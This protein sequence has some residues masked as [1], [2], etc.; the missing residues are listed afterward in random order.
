MAWRQQMNGETTGR[1][2][3]GTS[4]A[5]LGENVK[6]LRLLHQV[7]MVVSAAVLAF[8]LR[9]DPSN[10][11]RSALDELSVLREVSFD[12]WTKFVT[13][14]YK[15]VE[16]QNEKFVR[17]VIHDAGLPI[18]GH[19]ELGQF[20]CAEQPPRVLMPESRL[21]KDFDAFLS[22]TRTIGVFRL[23][24]VDRQYMVKHLKELVASRNST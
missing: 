1:G 19:P 6:A 4:D 24:A 23:G 18:A 9:P 8:A 22:G 12:G 14:R 21:V 16:D 15:G 11:Y 2:T 10:E 3:R 7:L 13:N 5:L 17:G 20:F